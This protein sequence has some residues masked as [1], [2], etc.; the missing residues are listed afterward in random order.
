MREMK[1]VTTSAAITGVCL[2]APLAAGGAAG[3]AAAA[4]RSS[5]PLAAKAAPLPA[6][7]ATGYPFGYVMDEGAKTSLLPPNDND[8]NQARVAVAPKL[9]PFTINPN[10]SPSGWPNAC[11]LTSL[12]QLKALEPSITGF[13]GNPVGTRA[14]LLGTGGRAPHNTEC[15]FNLKTTFQP[16]GYGST[17]S[18]VTVQF[19]EIDTGAPASYREALAGQ[20]GEAHKYPAQYADY[21]SLKNGVQCFDDGNELQCLKGDVN[22]WVSGQKVT[23][24]NNF[25]ADQAIWVDQIELPLAEVLGAELKTS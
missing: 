24:G 5:L 20:K 1:R 4:V 25:G 14:E 17:G 8:V 18:Y 2:L 13:R 15:Q 3:V 21:A 7:A 16:Q 12:P 6:G 11:N 19:E 22:F 10:G 23:G 9:G